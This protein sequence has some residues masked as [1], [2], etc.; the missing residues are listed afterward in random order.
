MSLEANVV[1]VNDKRIEFEGRRRLS[2][3]RHHKGNFMLKY[4]KEHVSVP[5]SAGSCSS[6]I[7]MLKFELREV[8]F[9]LKP[10]YFISGLVDAYNSPNGFNVSQDSPSQAV[11][12]GSS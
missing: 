3:V 1:S 12:H 2:D 9:N 4:F 5:L 8:T 6:K 7:L 11:F 10:L